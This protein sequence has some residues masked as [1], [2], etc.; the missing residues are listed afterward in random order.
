MAVEIFRIGKKRLKYVYVRESNFFVAQHHHTVHDSH[1]R[2]VAASMFCKSIPILSNWQHTIQRDI[3]YL[4]TLPI[5]I[6][7]YFIKK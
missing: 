5:A 3:Q 6:S 2:R 7:F 1:Q 4:F